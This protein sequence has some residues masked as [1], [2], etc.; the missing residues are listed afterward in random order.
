MRYWSIPTTSHNSRI[1]S[2]ER[3]KCPKR[4]SPR[5]C[6]A[7]ATTFASTTSTAGPLIFSRI[8]LKFAS[9]FQNVWRHLNCHDQQRSFRLYE[10]IEM[11]LFLKKGR[12]PLYESS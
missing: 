4:N 2:I 1:A 5:A 6:S 9:K 10:E 11:T 3:W 7:C 8:S 12:K